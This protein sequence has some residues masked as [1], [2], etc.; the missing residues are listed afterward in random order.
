MATKK[1]HICV[2][3]P[4][5]I[6][7]EWKI[8]GNNE[9]TLLQMKNM[10]EK[11]D[12]IVSTVEKTNKLIADYIEEERKNEESKREELQKKFEENEKKF[13]KIETVKFG[14][15]QIPTDTALDSVTATRIT[16]LTEEFNALKVEIATYEPT[17]IDDILLTFFW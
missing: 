11:V 17:L 1:E 16:T 12:W 7:L 8:K 6:E 14:I 5:L 9:L 15:N 13:V 3:E 4:K 10:N 2:K